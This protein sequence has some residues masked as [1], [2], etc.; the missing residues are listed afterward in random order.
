M[1]S[2]SPS[3]AEL[4]PLPWLDRALA[5][6]FLENVPDYIYFKDQE[7]R[8]IAVSMSL[9]RHLGC[10]SVYEVLG[11][12][13]ADFY[14]ESARASLEDE[15]HILRTGESVIGKL[16]QY[17]NSADGHVSWV[18]TSKLP[19]RGP[20][21]EITGTFGVS[22]DVT[23]SKEMEDQLEKANRDLRAAS[24]LAGM[25]EVATGA[26]H[27]VGNVVNSLNVSSSVL[28]AGLRQSKIESLGKI[29]A[30]M[31]EH[32]SDLADFLTRDPKGR[33]IPDFLRSLHRHSSEELIRLKKEVESLQKNVDHIKE[34]VT[35]QQS[36]ATM[37]GVVEPLSPVT[38]IEDALRINAASLVHHDVSVVRE[39]G[40]VTPVL[41]ERGRVLQILIN[42]IRNAKIA[43]DEGAPTH[44]IIT[45]RLEP[46]E[47]GTVRLSVQDNGV[48]IPAENLSRIF[49]H[50]FTTRAKGHG[51]GLHS[52]IQAAKDM[53]GTLTAFSYGRGSGATFTLELPVA[54][55]ARA[56]A[57]AEAV[58]VSQAVA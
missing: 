3:S 23:P 21:G 36:H 47:T 38:L 27:N 56:S 52:S 49:N 32:A 13:D 26:L 53:K 1:T 30:L 20:D 17:V 19:L 6:A 11:R 8:F 31:D 25:A 42:L 24:R 37:V 29:C 57:S 33:L 4:K 9:V 41:A 48:G 14:G 40:Q 35:M 44:K 15:Q 28:A 2:Q 55:A 22:K 39:F 7:S 54:P 46:T 58:S 5:A 45:L 16:E 12:T 10:G 18:L 50:G 51:F 43:L 34:I